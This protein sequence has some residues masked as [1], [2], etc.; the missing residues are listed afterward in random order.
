VGSEPIGVFN[1]ITQASS[2][3]RD[4]L[5]D[6]VGQCPEVLLA[7]NISNDRQKWLDGL[8][9]RAADHDQLRVESVD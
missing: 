2:P 3:S 7:H 8:T 4:S 5:I 6:V 9:E 1:D